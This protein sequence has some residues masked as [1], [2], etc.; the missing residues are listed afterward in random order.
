MAKSSNFIVR[1][2]ADFSE[3]KSEITKTQS[4]L[5]GFQ[6]KISGGLM[7][8]G[9]IAGITLGARA[10]FELGKQ[11][12]QTASDL[13]E[14]QNVVDVTF[15]QMSGEVND[16]AQNALKS[17]GLSELSAK[18]YASTM[19]AILKSSGL[20]GDQMKNMAINL[21]ELSADMASFYNLQ[22]D[23]A[24]EK[25]QAGIAGEV[26]PLRDLGINMTVAN[27][28]AF[29]MSRGINK[30]W[31]EMTQAEQVMTRYNYLLAVTSDAQGDFSRTSGTW[32]N[33]VKLLKEQWQKFLGLLGQGLIKIGLPVVKF[34]N[35]VLELLNMVLEK[36][37]QLYTSITGKQL[38]DASDST[39]GLSDSTSDLADSAGSAAD[40]QDDLAKKTKKAKKAAE[41]ALAPFD[42][43][44]VLQH[45]MGDNDDSTGGG[46][47]I[48]AG[49]TY[50]KTNFGN[51][52]ETEGKIDGLKKKAD[53]FFVWISDWW[54]K[55]KKLFAVPVVVPALE[56][57]DLK[58]PA[59]AVPTLEELFGRALWPFKIPALEFDGL[60]LPA[61]EMPTMEEL[62]GRILWPFKIPAPEFGSLKLPAFE[63]PT[64]EELFGKGLWPFTV[65]AP[66]F[67]KL[68][69]PI[70][71]P[72]WN[73]VPPVIAPIV[74][75]AIIYSTY[76]KS[77]RDM[78][79]ET[80]HIFDELN[81]T[82]NGKVT[83][84][85]YQTEGAL[86][87]LKL[88]ALGLYKGMQTDATTTT[89]AT[90]GAVTKTVEE[91][92]KS[93]E[94]NLGIHKKNVGIL[95]AA[96]GAAAAKNI[97]NGYVALGKN[98]IQNIEGYE[99]N[100]DLH[101]KKTAELGHNTGAGYNS[102]VSEGF[103]TLGKNMTQ[104][105]NNSLRSSK[106]WGEGQLRITADAA[107][108]MLDNMNNGLLGS[109]K[110]I[111]NFNTAT[112]GEA[113]G[114]FSP[115]RNFGKK[116]LIAGAIV[117]GIALSAFAPQFIPAIAGGLSSLVQPIAPAFG[118]AKG[119]IIN[120]PTIAMVGE[121]GREAVMPLENNTS[122]ID[123]LAGKIATGIVS[124]MQ[125]TGNSGNGEGTTVVL[126]INDR[127]IAQ[128]ILPALNDEAGRL[129]YEPILRRG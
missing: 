28:E 46:G 10:L 32:A 8:L 87:N 7:K 102:N 38:V 14:V 64:L 114:S 21:T 76:I 45:N 49:I 82:V 15:G 29:N 97:G 16:F 121:A 91:Q 41:S 34:L 75:P 70:Y 107:Q 120:K 53:A 51:V 110:S 18:K 104:F 67:E 40:A 44:N 37:G 125:I 3:I 65:P 31:K 27:L 36:I 50:P 109:W 92:S 73:L 112:G 108:G 85:S 54:N 118:L 100:Y 43:L 68:K 55:L 2:G 59:W 30:Q 33:Q 39:T 99:K 116:L 12:I 106:E 77:L 127:K 47:G 84:Q 26:K 78:A 95:G 25:I 119:G 71:E 48:D 60:K 115:T 1:G 20:A 5:G 63:V 6:S 117:G 9:K 17:Y 89:E 79:T 62:F 96:I 126:T 61:Y 11:A 94:D 58:L 23:V 101:A 81:Q 4:Q 86:S 93:I 66:E 122:W 13:T 24:F 103:N 72:N 88:R 80:G 22:N 56:F 98:Q 123:D 113:V 128:T 83:E 105:Q 35:K 69:N 74:I 57:A 90:K 129:G 42:E 124:T 111:K 52:E 19:G